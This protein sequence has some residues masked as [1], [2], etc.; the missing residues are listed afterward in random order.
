[1]Y[2]VTLILVLHTLSMSSM[3]LWRILSGK[4]EFEASAPMRSGPTSMSS[5]RTIVR[6][7][8]DPSFMDT[9]TSFFLFS[10]SNNLSVSTSASTSLYGSSSFLKI[11]IAGVYT[12]SC[13]Y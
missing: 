9:R 13:F 2:S 5:K 6:F 7:R 10:K 11:F 8:D 3:S 4:L 1:M 12:A